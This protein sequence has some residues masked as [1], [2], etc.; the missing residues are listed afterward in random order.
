MEFSD[1]F[2]KDFMLRTLEIVQSYK[3]EYDATLILNCLL[4]LLVV[5]RETSFEKI[6]EDNIDNIAKWGI[7]R[8]SIRKIG[9]P[10][11]VMEKPDTLRGLVYNLRNSVS[12]FQ[13]RP[14]H[15]N[16][17]VEGFSFKTRT[18]FFAVISL[19]ELN[20]FVEKLS[21]YLKGCY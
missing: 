20:I 19:E 17:V 9:K 1:K 7:K 21:H 15:K 18:G 6:P 8:N 4:G 10:T 3:G 16:Y 13:F 12:H 14:I 5:P 11:N 2:E